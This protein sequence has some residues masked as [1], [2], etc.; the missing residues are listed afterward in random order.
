MKIQVL[1]LKDNQV[2]QDNLKR[3]PQ[4]EIV[5]SVNG[6]NKEETIDEF[7]KLGIPYRGIQFQ[8]Y[9]MLANG[10]TKLKSIKH[11]IDNEIPYLA[12]I[13]D[14]MRLHD[15]FTDWI[16]RST[17]LF[18]EN[19]NLNI[20][21]LHQW[22]EGYVTSLDG[23]KRIFQMF[24]DKGMVNN[25]DVQL[26]FQS[27]KSLLKYCGYFSRTSKTNEGDCLK[28][29][30]LD[31]LYFSH[32]WKGLN[33]VAQKLNEERKPCVFEDMKCLDVE[34]PPRP[35]GKPD[36][37]S[38]AKIRGIINY[39]AGKG[40]TYLEIGVFRGAS[41]VSASHNNDCKCIGVDNF[42]QFND[43]GSNESMARERIGKYQNAE[44]IKDDCWEALTNFISNGLEVDTYFYD[45]AHD[46][47][48]Q[49]RGLE[50]ALPL[51]SDESY[52][53]VD[54][55]NWEEV[56]R[57]NDDFCQKHGYRSLFRKIGTYTPKEPD[58]IYTDT[59]HPL[60]W[61]GIEI[62]VKDIK[63]MRT[64]AQAE[65]LNML[66]KDMGSFDGTIVEIGSYA[67]EGAIIF[68]KHFNR[69]IAI[70]PWQWNEGE[71]LWDG[72]T[73]NKEEASKDWFPMPTCER[74]EEVFDAS[75][76]NIPNIIKMKAKDIDVLSE[77]ED[78]SL[79][80]VYIDST[81]TFEEVLEV[82]KRWLP[83]LKF[84]GYLSGHDFNKGSWAGV[85]DAVGALELMLN[86]KAVIY[87]DTSWRLQK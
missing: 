46:Y 47:D 2:V 15:G 28:T 82:A 81:H 40:K 65:G 52:I 26:N 13:E 57:A 50:V 31:S 72:F 87:Q 60:W 11:Q 4:I 42:S 54:D 80:A 84:G 53:I 5:Q 70:D 61:N 68:S 37:M 74:V 38:T 1:S 17:I 79:D 69:V 71:D 33:E 41:L 19:P 45:G 36:A 21:R 22:G 35:N 55:I 59:R 56:R 66:A 7:K 76:K 14:D 51:L 62:L 9:G 44:I 43:D 18:Q 29:D 75:V 39:L 32:E 86:Q 10:L 20:I 6:Y 24:L 85:V 83:K 34:F 23:A 8:T 27:G 77:F 48:S 25:I 64:G 58:T 12:F 3:F 73:G 78:E 16:K 63:S 67:G 49:L 30:E